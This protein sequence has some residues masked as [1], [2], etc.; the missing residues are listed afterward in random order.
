MQTRT[1]GLHVSCAR[2]QMKMIRKTVQNLRKSAEIS[3]AGEFMQVVA[4]RRRNRA[5]RLES[6]FFSRYRLARRKAQLDIRHRRNPFRMVRESRSF[7]PVLEDMNISVKKIRIHFRSVVD[8]HLHS[9]RP[10][11]SNPSSNLFSEPGVKKS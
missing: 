10:H 4:E 7:H 11:R 9:Y 3:V 6:H 1:D 8:V 5:C 2:K